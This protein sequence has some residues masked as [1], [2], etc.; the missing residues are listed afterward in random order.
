MAHGARSTPTQRRPRAGRR[1]RTAARAVAPWQRTTPEGKTGI[2]KG[3]RD[4]ERALSTHQHSGVE[5]Q[6]ENARRFV[7]L[8]GASMK[9]STWTTTT[10]S[11][12]CTHKHD[13]VATRRD[14]TR[15][16]QR[17]PPPPPLPRR[18]LTCTASN[19]Q[20]SI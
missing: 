1:R 16:S 18:A 20:P 14:L 19:T 15:A 11:D 17:K 13:K 10:T 9:T 3:A 5:R 7:R 2:K 4:K 6:H 8:F 12:R